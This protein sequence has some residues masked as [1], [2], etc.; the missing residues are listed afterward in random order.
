VGRGANSASRPPGSRSRELTLSGHTPSRRVDGE[1]RARWYDRLFAPVDVAPLVYA[2]IVFG[3]LMLVEVYRFFSHGWIHRYY[4]APSFTF[5]Y[6]GFGWVQP[7][8]ATGMYA[9]FTAMGVLAVLIAVG[10]FYRVAAALFALCITYVFLLDQANYLNHIYL[11]CLVA[12]L[13]ALVPAARAGSVDALRT[14]S[15]AQAVPAWCVWLLC[16]QIAIVYV[17][18]GIAKL[19]GDWLAGIPAGMFLDNLELTGPLSDSPIGRNAFAIGGLLFDLLVVPALLWR[20]TRW[21]ATAAALAFHLSNAVLF[22]IGIFPWLMLALTPLFWG[23]AWTRRIL[24]FAR[25]LPRSVEPAAAGPS[26]PRRRWIVAALAAYAAIQLLLPFRHWLYPGEVN[27]T[28]EGHNF[29]WH[30]KLRLKAG[31]TWYIARDPQSGE[32]RWISPAQHLSRRQARKMTTRP[33]MILRFAHEIARRLRAEGWSEDLEVR[34]VAK[35]SLNGRP[36]QYLIDPDVD[37]AR[38]SW[39]LA[40]SSWIVPLQPTPP[41]DHLEDDDDDDGAPGEADEDDAER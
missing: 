17:F 25:V 10:L 38:V 27:W 8:P 11:I 24:V 26:F 3:A 9:L 31:R 5:T 21:F 36:M 30:M 13:L 40:P 28:E 35:A 29:S 1:E 4:V 41:A 16:G 14:R 7:L 37:L 34:A 2:R 23:P 19:D 33:D 12:G 22:S 6:A 32:V 20:R 18:G 39:T 15:T